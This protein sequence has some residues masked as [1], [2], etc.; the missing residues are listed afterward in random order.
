MCFVF[1]LL[2]GCSLFHKDEP[3][4]TKNETKVETKTDA[5]K[6]QKPNG[7]IV[8]EIY[9]TG[10]GSWQNAYAR[11]IEEKGEAFIGYDLIYVDD[12]NVPE[13]YMYGNCEATGDKIA[14]YDKAN[15]RLSFMKFGR[16]GLSYIP[17]EGLMYKNSGH[18]DYYPVI[19]YQLYKGDVY[20]LGEGLFGGLDRVNGRMQIDENGQPIYQYEW[21][22]V[23]CTKEEFDQ[24]VQ[25]LFD[26]DKSIYAQDKYDKN[27]M[28]SMLRSGAV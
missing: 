17:N 22:G 13:L 3:A 9:G 25:E 5:I 18:M 1:V 6:G 26:I 15:D 8:S 16:L 11:Y 12:D 27:Q 4:D 19:I 10:Y 21:Q 2:C 20:L 14:I 28:L 24:R 23:R 7:Q